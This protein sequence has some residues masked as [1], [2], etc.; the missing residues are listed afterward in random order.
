M[1][2]RVVSSGFLAEVLAEC[3]SL[4][5]ATQRG[6]QVALEKQ[7]VEVKLEAERLRAEQA[8]SEVQAM[9]TEDRPSGL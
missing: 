5:D 3:A 2:S 1:G 8:A 7:D 4:Q 9:R 6:N